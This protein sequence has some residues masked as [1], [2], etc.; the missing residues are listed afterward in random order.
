MK[1]RSIITLLLLLVG[2]NKYLNAALVN[3]AEQ[4]AQAPAV[5]AT[6]ELYAHWFAAAEL[7]DLDT[8]IKLMPK[9][10]V[11]AVNQKRDLYYGYN[12]LMIAAARGHEEIVGLLLSPDNVNT[13]NSVTGCTALMDAVRAGHIYVVRRLLL[14]E[15]SCDINAQNKFGI[16][17]LMF[18]TN[19]EEI[20]RFLLDDMSIDVNIKDIYDQT[21]FAHA[22]SS[23]SKES[24]VVMGQ[25]LRVP[26]IIITESEV[27]KGIRQAVHAGLEDK[28]KILLQIIKI[29]INYRDR[30]NTVL[31][32][33]AARGYENIV[34]LLLQQPDININATNV[35]GATPLMVAAENGHE[36]IVRLLLTMQN[37]N[38]AANDIYGDNA[39]IVAKVKDYDSIAA[40][41]QDKINQLTAQA[42]DAIKKNDKARLQP[43]ITQLGIDHRITGKKLQEYIAKLFPSRFELDI[44]KQ[45][46]IAANR[47]DLEI[48]KKLAPKVDINGQD[49]KDFFHDTALTLACRQRHYTVVKWLLEIPGINVNAPTGDGSTPLMRTL[50]V[51]II[52]LLLQVPGINVNAKNKSGFTPL[53]YGSRCEYVTELLLQVPGIDVNAQN[54]HGATAL[55]NA[56]RGYENSVKL[57]LQ[58]P[59][60]NV[61]AVDIWCKTAL[62]EALKG[63][64]DK[65]AQL[66]M[67]VPGIRLCLDNE[68]TLLEAI[69]K[70]RENI[71]QLILEMPDI[72]INFQDNDGL[73][74]L[75]HAAKQYSTNTIKMLL[76]NPEINLNAQDKQGMTA[77]MYAL[78]HN[79]AEP[80]LQDPRIDVNIQNNKGQT[81]L[82]YILSR[83]WDPEMLDRR[84]IQVLKL[85]LDIPGINI[86]GLT[87]DRKTAL[88]YAVDHNYAE[89]VTLITKKL[90]E[91][92]QAA[93]KAIA[94]GNNSA[95]KKIICTSGPDLIDV[96]DADGNTL[97]H[98]AFLRNSTE[99]MVTLLRN[100]KDVRES[101][102]KKNK[103]GQIP[104][105]L[106][107]PASPIFALCMDLA[108]AP[109]TEKPDILTH[110]VSRASQVVNY[111]RYL[112]GKKVSTACAQCATP[113]C[114][115]R[116]GQC[117][118]VYYCDS[119][120]QKEHW[121]AHKH[122]CKEPNSMWDNLYEFYDF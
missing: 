56:A 78:E 44:Q 45:W 87:K 39:L 58:V 20:T 34:K 15:P 68:D 55:M 12:A 119:E 96:T 90:T 54:S 32:D 37:I 69:K 60:I 47:G 42:F 3:S 66:L 107:S 85:L 84:T 70:G 11:N 98:K 10:D 57:L 36:S 103:N 105:E 104:L 72:N 28:L 92:P 80:L 67:Q 26:K 23:H 33:A 100:A 49:E 99:I 2:F 13:K 112:L 1:L 35:D 106:I 81:A 27:E 61:N 77:L 101:L 109:Q 7:G 50:D 111:A 120:C 21:A 82:M 46:F 74:P 95:L 16:T 113:N 17:A 64:H 75:M 116:C 91:L 94:D 110:T 18:A 41:I 22:A 52:K 31:H 65:I 118:Q 30:G 115:E 88:Q 51:N 121:K 6:E 86:R 5:N 25:L 14:Q 48:L 71:V 79:C 93:F 40:L 59:N 114:I 4:V 38:I 122:R 97:L 24:E 73:T 76:L 8:I 83:G 53:I 89:V 108:F 9:L 29:N 117:K 43:I 102:C 62:S 19:S 63:G